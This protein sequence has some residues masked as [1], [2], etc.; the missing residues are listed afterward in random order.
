[1]IE[2]TQP[3]ELHAWTQ[4]LKLQGKCVGFVPTMGCLHEGHL[5]LVR[6]AQKKADAVVVSLFVNPLQFG[7][8]EDFDRYPR[9]EE[10]DRKLL[11]DIGTEALFL[12]SVDTMYPQGFSTKVVPGSL[13]EG[14]CGAFR[15]QFF[16]GVCTVVARLINMVGCDHL[17]LGEK[18]FQQLQVVRQMV[19]DLAL[20]V[21]VHAG[22][23]IRE[24]DGLAMSSRNRYLS[25]ESREQATGMYRALN[26]VHRA[27]NEGETNAVRLQE[28]GRDVLQKHGFDPI[29]YFE[30]CDSETLQPAKDAR[31]GQRVL[32]AAFLKGVRLIDNLA[33]GVDKCSKS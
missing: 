13:A 7:P 26:S 33:L 15:P 32:A 10:Q 11:K 22:S 5:S 9:T 12:P 3:S 6:Q 24:A 27:F 17:W 25:I 23:T 30:I 8:T 21:E 18:D 19:R 2:L 28:L 31:R 1:M 14:L 4:A 29:Q 16:S 20:P